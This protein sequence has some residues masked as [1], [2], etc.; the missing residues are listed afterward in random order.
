MSEVK[1]YIPGSIWD[2][3]PG[4]VKSEVANMSPEKQGLFLEEYRRKDRSVGVAYLLWFIIGL[5]YIYLGRLGWQIFYW[6]TLGGLLIWTLIDL[7]RIPGMVRER[8][9]DIAV[10][11]LRDLKI[12]SG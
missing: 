6:V 4:L 7:F 3:L 5:H 10:D 12:I 9:R 1:L 8:N 11:V 2:K